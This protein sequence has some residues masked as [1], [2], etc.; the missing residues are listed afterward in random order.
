MSMRWHPL[1]A[2]LDFG[3]HASMPTKLVEV[4][5]DNTGLPCR[6]C[7]TDG[8]PEQKTALFS[9][10]PFLGDSPYRQYGPIFVHAEP[11]CQLASC[12]SAVEADIPEQQYRWQNL[13]VRA[14]DEKHMMVGYDVVAGRDLIKKAEEVF[15]QDGVEYLHVHYAGPRCFAVRID[16]TGY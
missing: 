16:K 6:K 8:Q 15:G 10:D 11:E 12:A 3:T 4:T 14:F 7:L 13:S 1:P 9:Y 5:T 2:P